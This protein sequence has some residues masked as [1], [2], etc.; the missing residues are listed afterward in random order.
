MHSF[1]K[2]YWPEDGLAMKTVKGHTSIIKPPAAWDRKLK[3]KNETWYE[4]IKETR[5]RAAERS[6]KLQREISNYSDLERLR[7]KAESIQIKGKMLKREL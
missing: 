5:K 3:E 7:M 2:V 6:E 1:E 4:Q